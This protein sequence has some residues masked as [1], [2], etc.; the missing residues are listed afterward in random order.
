MRPQRETRRLLLLVGLVALIGA[1]SCGGDDPGDVRGCNDGGAG[2]ALRG[3]YCEDVE[4]LFTEVKALTVSKSLRIEYV[5][6]IGGG[7]EKTLQIILDGTVVVL[8]P[9]VEI[10]LLESRAQIRR[11]VAEAQTPLTLT[12]ELQNT[13]TLSFTE[14][15]GAIGSAVAGKFSLLFKSGRTLAGDFESVI[16]DARPGS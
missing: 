2:N 10:N 9:N 16:E 15:T 5:R 14:Y 3:S 7:S 1:S 6:P 11:I 4:M 8:E 12:G 13:S